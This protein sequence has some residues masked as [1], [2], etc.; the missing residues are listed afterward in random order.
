M[1]E[2]GD[3]IRFQYDLGEDDDLQ[4]PESADFQSLL[5]SE[6]FKDMNQKFRKRKD[7]LQEIH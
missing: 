4:P 1:R 6:C 3:Y 2:N 7:N 5:I